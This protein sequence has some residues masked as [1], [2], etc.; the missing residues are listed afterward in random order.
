M[1]IQAVLFDRDNTLL[2]FDTAAIDALEARIARAAPHV[3]HG[4]AVA[5]W[6]SW[7]GGWP[8][9]PADEAAFWLDFW[10]EF[11]MRYQ[12]SSAAAAHIQQIGAFYHTCFRAFSDTLD[13]LQ[14]LRSRSI[15]LAV[16]TNFEL[17]SVDLTF[18]HVGI[19]P[20][21][22]TALLSSAAIGCRKP[23]PR[24]YLI[25]ARALALPPEACAFVDDQPENVA[26]A[27][28]L[29]MPAWLLDRQDAASASTLRRIRDLHELIS[30]VCESSCL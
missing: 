3:P 13:C 18:Q 26:A 16:L 23:D 5:C 2:H 22:F 1:Q 8:R 7:S 9:S 11:A 24:A 14:A 4:A 17:P 10:G 28:A 21:W 27:G 6:L 19:D 20:G 15:R 25:A 12:L 29:G 30:C